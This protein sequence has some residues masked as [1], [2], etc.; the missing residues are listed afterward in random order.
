VANGRASLPLTIEAGKTY[1]LSAEVT[2]NSAGAGVNWAGLGFCDS[3]AGSPLT[4]G[5]ATLILTHSGA[6][7]GYHDGATGACSVSGGGDTETLVLILT[8]YADSTPWKV[9]Y[10]QGDKLLAGYTFSA[11]PKITQVVIGTGGASAI[12]GR[13]ENFRCETVLRTDSKP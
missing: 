10:Y 13:F 9:D 7:K 4:A 6:I 12:S 1:K 8:T 5:A 11:A 2:V 3:S